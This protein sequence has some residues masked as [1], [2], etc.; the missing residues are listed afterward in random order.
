[1]DSSRSSFSAAQD[2]RTDNETCLSSVGGPVPQL[3]LLD[4]LFP[5][6]SGVSGVV[7]RYLGIDLNLYVPLLVL[8]AGLTFAWDYVRD[9][10]WAVISN[11]FMST[12]EV[13]SAQPSICLYH[14]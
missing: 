10:F 5:G 3:A 4:L 1:M 6:F 2:R 7:L 14:S 8:V 9:Y 11:H 12:V 13:A